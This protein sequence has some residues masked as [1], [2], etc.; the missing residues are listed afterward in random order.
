MKTAVLL[1]VLG[2]AAIVEA[3]Q[4]TRAPAPAAT[5]P[6]ALAQA[7]EQFLLAHRL[8]DENDQ[9]GAIQAYRR[10]MALDPTAADIV[11]SLADLYLRTNR[12]AEAIAMGEQALK[13][14]PGNREA[15]RVLGTIYAA[16]LGAENA[17]RESQREDLARATRHLEQATERQPGGVQPDANLRA[18]LARLYIADAAYDKAIPILSELVK[19][20]PGWPDGASLLADAYA[21]ANRPDEAIQFLQEAARDNPQLY[22][23]LADFYARGRRYPEAAGAYEQALAGSPR[24][25]DLRV[26]YGSMLL[27]AGGPD[28]VAKARDTL[29]EAI[30][31]RATDERALYLLAQAEARSGD[32]VAAE[33]AARKLIAQNATNPRGYAVLAE[34]LEERRQYRQVVD[35]LAPAVTRFRSAPAAESSFALSLLMPH[36]GFAYAQ[37]GQYD[38]AIE[39]F[40]EVRK[41]SPH[42]P[43]VNGYLISAQLAAKRFDE[44]AE[45][46]RAARLD[47]PDD[48]RFVRLE[49]Q[50]L[51]QAGRK[52]QALAL[53]EGV[54]ARRADDPEAQIALARLYADADRGA[55]AVKVLQSA[56]VR[57]PAD[58]SVGFELGSVLEKQK[59]FAD[60]ETAFRGVIARDPSHAAALNY[61]GYMLAERGERLAESVE[62]IKRALAVEPENGSYLDSLGWAYFKDGQLGPAEEHLKRAADQLLTNSVVQDHYGD[63]LVRLGRFQ[64]AIEAW[65]RA[66]AG[67]GDSIDRGD[68]GSKIRS[69]RQKLSR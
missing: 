41:L 61:L 14:A 59:R 2:A 31:L 19:Q 7:Y 30:A 52:D 42:D 43:A 12:N 45:T 35:A 54:A 65:S 48:I 39:A 24:S 55:Q 1:A 66:L 23:T 26:R 28:E 49:A 13:I 56:Q 44:A 33:G 46:A 5:P 69:A 29:R 8:D 38:R 47:R 21:S 4:G 36:L 63:V 16:R 57:F 17:T 25:F 18:M 68:I 64:D 67:D 27:N 3:G 60:A 51:L 32:Y 6:A 58:T 53:V 20:E 11:S 9:E 10:A 22:S 50:A 37:L 40:A 62:L 34:A 15:H